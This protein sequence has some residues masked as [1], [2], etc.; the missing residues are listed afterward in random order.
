MLTALKRFWVKNFNKLILFFSVI[1]FLIG[2]LNFFFIFEVTAQ[3]NDECLWV[4][5]KVSSDSTVIVF[6]FVKE[7]GVTWN[8]GIRDGDHLIAIDGVRTYSTLIA[9]R[10]LD[11]VHSGDYATYTVSRNGNTFEANVMVKKLITFNGLAF[12]LLSFFWLIVGFIVI[13]AKPEGK[14][15]RLFYRVGVFAILFSMINLIF[16]GWQV[17]NPIFENIYLLLLVDTLWTL[18]GVFLPFYLIKFFCY[19]PQE[20]EIIKKKWFARTINIAPFAVFIIAVAAKINFVY[21]QRKDFLY[22]VIANGIT[23]LIV[24]GLFTGLVMLIRSYIKLKSQREKKPILVIIVAYLI[25]VAALF[26]TLTLAA[27]IAGVIFNNPYYFMPIILIA[28]LPIA[29]GYSIFRYSLMDVSEIVKNTIVYGVATVIIAGLYFLIIYTL[30]QS[31]SSAIGTEYEGMIAG[32]VFVL[33]AII[34]QS[35]K[36]KFQDFLTE[37]FYPE[38]FSFQKRLLQFSGEV[39]SIVG[40]EN[41]L[42]STKELFVQSLRIENFGLML[43]DEKNVFRLVRKE[44]VDNSNF[45]IDDYDKKLEK[46]F[47]KRKLLDQKLVLERQE[48]DHLFQSSEKEILVE[49]IYTI[50]PLIMKQKLI[51]LLLFGLKQSGS[52]F[53]GK[54]IYLLVSAANQTAVSIENARLHESEIEKKR[55]ER[56]LENARR[57]Q[58][59]LLPKEFPKVQKLDLSGRMIPA[60]HVGGDY[61]DLIKISD[62]KLFVVIGDVSGKGLSAAFYMS[63]LQTMIRLYCSEERSPKEILDEVNKNVYESIE[64]N[65]FITV[66]LALFDVE[67]NRVKFCRAGHTPL[68]KVNSGALETIQPKGMGIGL[69]SGELFNSSLEEITLTLQPNDL[70]FFY[71]DGVTELMDQKDQLFGTEKV[72]RLLLD[73]S[74][75][76][77]SEIQSAILKKLSEFRGEIPQYDDVTILLVKY[78][79]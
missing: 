52:Q 47:E 46:Y 39:A 27:Q 4:Q 67:T 62:S 68:M 14:P 51:G 69:N 59:S 1:L 60:M 70:F 29:F 3:S 34:F 28:L 7:G 18:G 44:G 42:D 58:E 49:K 19:F 66:S 75:E 61:F 9:T 38:Q 16:R 17:A 12:A 30:G 71:S 79:S 11:K 40:F 25:G 63:K 77:C 48:F 72:Q 20:C 45:I 15:Q 8:A 53:T 54:D 43:K 10:I 35:T 2:L 65:W 76:N 23:F 6:K 5:E 50:I 56:D 26:Y 21:L 41:V 73:N 78:L 57:M 36:D 33:S 24:A 22:A 13:M 55:L 31:I 74:N 64:R 32:V 37:K